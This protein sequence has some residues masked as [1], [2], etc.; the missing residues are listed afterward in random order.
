VAGCATGNSIVSVGDTADNYLSN[1]SN[2]VVVPNMGNAGDGLINHSMYSLL[3]RKSIRFSVKEAREI[4]DADWT[5]TY[6]IMVNGAL[7]HGEHAMDRLIRLLSAGSARMILH[8]ATIQE[9][10]ILLKQLPGSTVVIAR[11]PVTFQYV[12]SIRSDITTVLSEDATMAIADGDADLPDPSFLLRA[13]YRTRLLLRTIQLGFPAEFA[14]FPERYRSGRHQLETFYA[15]R[16]DDESLNHEH[17]PG[18]NVDLSEVCGGRQSIEHAEASA[19]SLLNVIKSKKMIRT[20]RLHVAIGCAL[21]EVECH[22]SAN[23]YFKCEAIYSHSLAKRF[24]FIKWV[25]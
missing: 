19:G 4:K 5:A 10:D 8:S 21:V 24:P 11:E 3:K 23:K 2:L 20:D 25:N 17:H 18:V 6:L 1:H 12:R 13:Q 15:L 16:K 22:F 9:R 7:H 14:F